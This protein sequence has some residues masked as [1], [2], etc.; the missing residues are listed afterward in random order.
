MINKK[1]IG[2]TLIEAILAIAI[3]TIVLSAVVVAVVSSVNN[4]QSSTDRSFALDYAEEGLDYLRD[5][6][7]EDFAGFTTTYNLK[8]PLSSNYYCLSDDDGAVPDS[9]LSVCATSGPGTGN[10]AE[11]KYLRKVFIHYNPPPA[12][13][14][15]GRDPLNNIKC[16]GSG[17]FASSIVYWTD[18]KCKDGTYCRSVELNTCFYNT[19]AL[20][21]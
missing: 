2:S 1:E 17:I 9:D 14:P 10:V 6:K 18:S 8:T 15:G 11:G 5:L 20:S 4:S 12:A 3:V 7:G 16:A 13:S 19:S 21:S